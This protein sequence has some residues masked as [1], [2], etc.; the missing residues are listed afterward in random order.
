M[1]GVRLSRKRW[2][3]A[4]TDR[5][6]AKSIA[7]E[8][9]VDPLLALVLTARGLREPYEIDEFLDDDQQLADPCALIDMERA[10]ARLNA[11]VDAFERIAVY[12]DYDAD[13][14]TATAMV[15]D[16]LSGRGADVIYTVPE[17]A[18]GYGMNKDEIARL[19]E[20]GVSLIVTVDNGVTAGEEIACAAAL[21]I[22]VIV[23]DHHL[24]PKELP[25]AYAVVDP[26]RAD[27]PSAFKQYAGVGIAFLLLCAA[28][29]CACEELLGRYGDLVAIGT[30]ADLMPL[31]GENRLLV[32]RGLETIPGLRPG[33]RALAACAG[34]S[35]K[36]VSAQGVAFGIAPRLNAAGRMGLCDR[37]VRLLTEPDPEQAA[38][39]AEELSADNAERQRLEREIVAEAEKRI[40]AGGMQHDRVL[41]VS[42]EGWRHGIIGIAASRLCEKYGRP[43]IVISTH[44]GVTV[45]SARSVA[46]FSIYHAISAC[47]DLLVRF[48]GH[49]LAAGLTIEPEQIDEFRARVNAYAAQCGEM[50]FP[51]LAI[52]CKLT[53]AAFTPALAHA[54]EP[55]APYGSGNPV[56]VFGLFRVRLDRVAPVGGG[57]HL[58]LSVSRDGVTLTAMLFSTPPDALG[59]R[60][61]D[62]VDLAVT[63]EASEYNGMEQLTL[64]VK[65]IRASGVDEDAL[66][67]DMR[68]YERV[69]RGEELPAQAGAALTRDDV[70]QVFRAVRA[71]GYSGP[72][73]ALCCRAGGLGYLKTRLAL[74][75]LGEL[76]ILDVTCDG[77]QLAV[78]PRPVEGKMDLEQS[79][80][81]RRVSA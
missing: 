28:E 19:K 5:E 78:R 69:C 23:T 81:Y 65:G 76:G 30:I 47:A 16:Y 29:G 37:A 12:G 20:R 56:P 24:P 74:D 18:D 17:R 6:L 63:A 58:R 49:E 53:P 45:G 22:D 35:G 3:V 39:L 80:L 9:G 34:L 36:P 48:G 25:A 73:E 42:G 33:V 59:F 14:V 43:C 11:A 60:E 50:P 71:Q 41:V 8:C 21:G 32:R 51:P 4:K 52:D 55:L 54:L 38:L 68:L 77:E 57:K 13:G 31:T 70:A 27:C 1:R 10:A 40:R 46:G 61:G 72:A 75:I 62:T 64:S 67:A 79:A 66:L 7:Q 44:D 2:D 15:Y 26:H